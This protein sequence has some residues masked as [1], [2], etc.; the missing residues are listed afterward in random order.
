MLAM[1]PTCPEHGT[2][3]REDPWRQ[4]CPSKDKESGEECCLK[5]DE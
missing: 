1:A 3:L 5:F 4:Y 2:A